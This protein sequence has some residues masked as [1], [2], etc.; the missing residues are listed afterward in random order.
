MTFVTKNDTDYQFFISKRIK[1]KDKTK[2]SALQIFSR[3]CEKAMQQMLYSS[4]EIIIKETLKNVENQKQKFVFKEVDYHL[5]EKKIVGE[6]KVSFDFHNALKSAKKQHKNNFEKLLNLG[7]SLQYIIID[8][9][10]SKINEICIDEK[11]TIRISGRSLFDY[12]L[13]TGLIED[14]DFYQQMVEENR[15]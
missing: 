15:G 2:P 13:N 3:I 11:P 14:K 10:N 7:Y 1:Q 4:D 6:I 8:M 5:P 12:C 9:K